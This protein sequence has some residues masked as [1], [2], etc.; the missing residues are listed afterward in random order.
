MTSSES[1]SS[2]RST[3]FRDSWLEYA[4]TTNQAEQI[5]QRFLFPSTTAIDV[6]ETDIEGWLDVVA[7]KGLVGGGD[8]E[9]QATDE[10]ITIP[11]NGFTS[12]FP[13]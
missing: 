4:F 3:K 9:L 10:H 6:R 2:N 8:T 7:E 11:Y 5:R 12:P 1:P 13:V